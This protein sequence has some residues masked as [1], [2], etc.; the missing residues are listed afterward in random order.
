MSWIACKWDA[1]TDG[2]E[3]ISDISHVK[4]RHAVHDCI[5]AAEAASTDTPPSLLWQSPKLPEDSERERNYA[6]DV[7][8]VVDLF[9][10]SGTFTE[11]GWLTAEVRDYTITKVAQFFPL[12]LPKGLLRTELPPIVEEYPPLIAASKV[13]PTT[14]MSWNAVVRELKAELK[15]KSV[16]SE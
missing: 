1:E 16:K 11:A 6:T 15:R 8:G 10:I 4:R 13:P 2:V 7:N 5:A 14:E 9:A 3:V 12:K